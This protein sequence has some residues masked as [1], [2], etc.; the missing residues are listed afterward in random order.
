MEQTAFISVKALYD[1]FINDPTLTE[2][3]VQDN[4]IYQAYS[5]DDLLSGLFG[6]N[7]RRYLLGDM[8][9]GEIDMYTAQNAAGALSQKYVAEISEDLKQII[10][11][12]KEIADKKAPI[13]GET[14]SVLTNEIIKAIGQHNNDT[15]IENVHLQDLIKELIAAQETGDKGKLKGLLEDTSNLTAIIAALVAFAKY[16]ATLM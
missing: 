11:Q 2:Y 6:S 13:D 16:G 7:Y 4:D 15:I 1:A 10:S 8:E 14:A 3:Y 12:L 9:R 5:V